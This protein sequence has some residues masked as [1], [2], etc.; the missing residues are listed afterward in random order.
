MDKKWGYHSLT[1][2]PLSATGVKE[3][4]KIVTLWN[5][6]YEKLVKLPPEI[7][8]N[9]FTILFAESKFLSLY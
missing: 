2:H 5:K 9:K 1:I 3:E 8:M 4:R 6:D 7:E